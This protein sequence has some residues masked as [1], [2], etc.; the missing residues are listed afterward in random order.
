MIAALALTFLF[1][2]GA[3]A[4]GPAAAS[5]APRADLTDEVLAQVK[6]DW[7]RLSRSDLDRDAYRDK[8]RFHYQLEE[9]TAFTSAAAKERAAAAE[10]VLVWAEETADTNASWRAHDLRAR[11]LIL[12]DKAAARAAYTAAL[13]AYPEVDYAIPSKH[14]SFHHVANSRALLDLEIDGAKAAVDALLDLAG[15]DGR[16]QSF[17]ADGIEQEFIAAGGAAELRRL[18]AGMA[19][20]LEDRDRRLARQLRGRELPDVRTIG[21][22]PRKTFAVIGADRETEEKRHLVVVMPGGNGQA[23]DF[24]PWVTRIASPL[25][26]RYVFAVLSAPVWTEDQSKRVVWVTEQWKKDFDAAF[27]VESFAREVAAELAD[28]AGG[29]NLLFAWSSGGPAT[30]ETILSKDDTFSGAYV[31]ASVFKPDQLDMRRARGKRFVLEQG[32]A[33]RVTPF[34]FAEKAAK[35]L[36]KKGAKTKLVEFE[37]GHGFAMPNANRSLREALAWLVE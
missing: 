3:V 28:E 37:G 21:G 8:K 33:D 23:M 22:D 14:G 4:C 17:Y 15:E 18:Y 27:T 5:V 29:E 10:A 13:E 19:D 34:R 35:D 1:P 9:S 31:L 25:T 30:Y 11:L 24:L 16:M 32:R 12:D 7:A 26:D 6:S 36:K 2:S 20:A